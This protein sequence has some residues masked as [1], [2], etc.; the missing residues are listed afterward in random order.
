MHH[1]I[2]KRNLEKKER[3]DQN[4]QNGISPFDVINNPRGHFKE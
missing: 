4:G 1:K 3:F 2:I